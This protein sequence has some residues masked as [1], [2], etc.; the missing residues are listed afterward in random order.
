[1]LTKITE[2]CI[3]QPKMKP[4]F[5]A[6][7]IFVF[8]F[9]TIWA[10]GSDDEDSNITPPRDRGEESIAAQLEI[11]DFLATHFYNYEDFQNPP[12]G[13]DFNIVIDSLVGDNVG[14]IALI[15]QVESKMVVDRLEDDVTYKLYYLKA[16]QGS[17]DSPDFPDITVVK[18]VGM[19]LDL[20]PFDSSSQP[21]AFDLTGV[22]NGFQ[23]V[24]IEL[25][26]AG[27]FIKNPDGTT[28][29]EDFGVGAMFI[30]S[31]L[32][33]FNNPP[34]SSAIPLYEQ[35]VFTF[36]LLET[37]QGDQDGDGVPSIYEDIDGNG[38][39]ENDDTDDDFTPNFADADDDNDGVPTSQE[40]LDENGVRITDPALYPDVDGDGTPDYLDSD[41]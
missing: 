41:S 14:K 2:N 16:V 15:D 35:L 5:K 24:A 40:I 27:S 12:A 33:Y 32:G 19:K 23:D 3:L 29:F 18:Y 9:I 31:G 38:Q 4:M 11:E 26:S 7:F 36:Q 39:E 25:N 10:C 17:G 37:F 20:E 28:T 34:T 6:K 30:P 21:V 13:F 22:V 8:L 1:M